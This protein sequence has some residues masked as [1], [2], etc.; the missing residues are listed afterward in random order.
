MISYLSWIAINGICKH[1]FVLLV[2]T[3]AGRTLKQPPPFYLKNIFILIIFVSQEYE[4]QS[5]FLHKRLC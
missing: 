3:V 5:F 2:S 1:K 4:Q